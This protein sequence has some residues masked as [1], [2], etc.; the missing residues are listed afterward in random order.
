M[1]LSK[2]RRVRFLFRTEA[3]DRQFCWFEQRGDDLY[4]GSPSTETIEGA[5]V[6]LLGQSAKLTVPEV[7]KKAEGEPT[8]ASFHASGEFHIKRGES[9]EDSPMKW[10]RKEEIKAPYRI[11]ALVSKH[12]KLYPLYASDKSLTRKQS[13]AFV[14]RVTGKEETTRHYFEFFV[15]PEG[16]F[17][18][19]PPLLSITSSDYTEPQPITFSLS[20]QLIL[21]TRHLVFAPEWSFSTWHP[22]LALWIHEDDHSQSRSGTQTS[23]GEEDAENA[24]TSLAESLITLKGVSI[25]WAWLSEPLLQRTGAMR[26]FVELFKGEVRRISLPRTWVNKGMKK[27]REPNHPGSR[28]V[29]SSHQNIP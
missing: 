24:G 11:A 7:I 1:I 5:T 12:P 28:T 16:R 26:N 19:P 8:K 15:S 21:V 9:P 4:F 3:G 13:S 23:P 27:G 10:P 25:I 18:A 14:F 6:E 22:E 29:L 20:E 2:S 17:T